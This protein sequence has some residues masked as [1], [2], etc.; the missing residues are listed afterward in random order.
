MNTW[1]L[2]PELTI[3]HASDVHRQWTEILARATQEAGQ[4][5]AAVIDAQAMQHIDGAGLQLLTSLIRTLRER[6]FTVNCTGVG[7]NLMASAQAFGIAH[8]F[9]GEPS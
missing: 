5:A 9:E 3:H 7:Q 4:P 1:P 6:G 8:L 2:P